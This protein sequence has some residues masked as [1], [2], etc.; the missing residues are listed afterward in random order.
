MD[1]YSPKE[2]AKNLYMCPFGK[3]P[4]A[5]F[6]YL[7]YLQGATALVAGSIW[8]IKWICGRNVE[9]TV[10]VSGDVRGANSTH[11]V[12]FCSDELG[13]LDSCWCG[14]R[15]N[16]EVSFVKILGHKCGLNLH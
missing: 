3:W 11:Q 7:C 12:H 13:A 16:R 2:L 5:V 15:E 6:S 4:N 1:G 10:M 8:G 9:A 14:R